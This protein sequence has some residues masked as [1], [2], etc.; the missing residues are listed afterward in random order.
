MISVIL[1]TYNERENIVNLIRD[2]F[3]NC[4]KQEK[5]EIIVIDDNSPDGTHKL[6]KKLND[7]RVIAIKRIKA[8]G[9]ASAFNRGIIESTGD[10]LVW[11][12]ADM[13]MPA[14]MIPKMYQ[15]LTKE[16]FDVAIGS[17]YVSGGK[18]DRSRLRVL[19]SLFI[20]RFATKVLGYGIQDY[21]SGFVMVKR[22]VFNEVTIIPTGYGE[23]FIE[24]IYNICQQ[25]FKVCE[26]GYYFRDRS[27]EQ[28]ESKSFPNL[29]GF[30]TTG[31]HYVLRILSA[32]Y[33]FRK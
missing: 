26:I 24:F 20:N 22:S 13:C 5:M 3:S 9:L 17:R 4:P 16:K 18:D 29:K 32:R 28:G 7:T 6:V 11:M 30:I 23:Y 33:R 25:G 10:Y 1:A 2:L 12:D 21:D 19:S 15:K 14:D 27:E 31:M 8:R